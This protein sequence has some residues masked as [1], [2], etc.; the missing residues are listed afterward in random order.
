MDMCMKAYP[1]VF[2]DPL[3]YKDHIV[4]I[5]SFHA[6]MAYLKMIGKKINGSGLEDILIEAELISSGSLKGVMSGKHFDRSMHCH[7]VMLEYL[8]RLFL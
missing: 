2:N 4:L 5:G 8:E 3:K 1:W 7:K 6:T